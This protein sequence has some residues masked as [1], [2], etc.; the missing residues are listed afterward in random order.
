MVCIGATIGKAGYAERQIATNQ[1]VNSWTPFS[2]VLPKFIY[3]QMTS[4]DFQ[5]RVV[6]G[7]G[8]A[9]L[10]IINKSKWSSLRV[11][12]PSTVNAQSKIVSDLDRLL[13]ES[14]NLEVIYKRKLVALTELKKS[15]LHRAFTGEL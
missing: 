12:V 2:D 11:A 15:L 14:M 1:Q 9:T 8:Q 13:E 3:Y 7:S 6:E 5:R 4:K 10:P